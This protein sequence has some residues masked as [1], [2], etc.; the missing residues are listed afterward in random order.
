M[1]CE[2]ERDICSSSPILRELPFSPQGRPKYGID[3]LKCRI[4]SSSIRL[5]YN[6]C[7]QNSI[8]PGLGE[9]VWTRS[10]SVILPKE[11]NL[12]K[13]KIVDSTL[14]DELGLGSSKRC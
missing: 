12:T 14:V 10:N 9:L 2:H 13:G 3:S 7:M 4:R 8:C 6:N 1:Y 5:S 11:Q